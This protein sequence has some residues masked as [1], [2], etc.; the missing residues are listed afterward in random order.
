M[1]CAAALTLL[2]V[3]APAAAQTSIR[4]RDIL[5]REHSGNLSPEERGQLDGIKA[6]KAAEDAKHEA[7]LTAA[8]MRQAQALR[9]TPP[10]PAE[11]NG[12]LGSWRLGDDQRS[13]AG[14]VDVLTSSRSSLAESLAALSSFDK[15][16]CQVDWAG[17]I[18]F[19]SSTYS[20]RKAGGR[21]V[22]GA[23]I[24]Y[25]SGRRG[26]KE[27]I[28]AITDYDFAMA[29]E[30]ASP[31]SIVDDKGC[32]LVRVGASAA[33]AAANAA[34][35]PGNARMAAASPSALPAAGTAPQV[36]AVAPAPPRST[37]VAAVNGSLLPQTL[38]DVG[39][40]CGG[41]TLIMVKFCARGGPN[42]DCSVCQ[43]G[44]P[45]DR[46]ADSCGLT[47][48]AQLAERIGGCEE[49]KVVL[50]NDGAATFAPAARR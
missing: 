49:G 42:A 33:K 48:R 30:I 13:K 17:G 11:R 41:K 1:S 10:L 50:A 23:P 21:V 28:V 4:D 40:R 16:G 36:A 14:A 39:F 7:G 31:N 38:E 27:V 3:A 44:E 37:A 5:N 29:F 32:V 22:E 15:F 18:T 24:A 46:S 20:Q 8:R 12:L 9:K 35:V 6:S 43:L 34:T 26:A 2:A 47:T 25:R 19:T 45:K